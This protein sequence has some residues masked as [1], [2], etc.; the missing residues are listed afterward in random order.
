MKTISSFASAI[1]AITAIACQPT[2]EAPAPTE[3]AA[4][5]DEDM[6]KAQTD[7][8]VAAWA[9]ADSESIAALFA[10]EGDSVD[11]AGVH[12][13]GADAIRER[14]QGMFETAYQGTSL[15]L[16]T[17]STRFLEPTV[18]VV[19]GKYQITGMKSSDGTELPP[20]NGLFT[21]V[22]VKQDGVWVLH[23]S[24]PMMPIPAPGT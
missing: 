24:R 6:L 13:Q 1:L 4:M 3:E 2:A 10:P 17:T 20:V 12:Y 5:S 11:P 22:A 9:A 15:S 16:T 18:A 19:D 14:Y 7:A 21:N 8:F 23:C